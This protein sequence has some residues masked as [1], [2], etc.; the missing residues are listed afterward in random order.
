LEGPDA[1][2]FLRAHLVGQAGDEVKYA[3]ADARGDANGVFDILRG[4]YGER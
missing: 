3:P 1:V 4:I 2:D